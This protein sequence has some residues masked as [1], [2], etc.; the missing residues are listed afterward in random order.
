MECDAVNLVSAFDQPAW[1]WLMSA[2]QKPKQ[3]IVVLITAPLWAAFTADSCSRS[4]FHFE[5][6]HFPHQDTGYALHVFG[7]SGLAFWREEDTLFSEN[8]P[9]KY[10]VSASYREIF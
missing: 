6:F 1:P 10:I 8:S 7:C 5:S 9:C 2:G 3:V 4:L